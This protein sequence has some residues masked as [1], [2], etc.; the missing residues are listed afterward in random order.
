[1]SMLDAGDAPA[2]KETHSLEGVWVVELNPYLKS[3]VFK[4]TTVSIL[5]YL[6]QRGK[7]LEPGKSFGRKRCRGITENEL[8]L[9]PGVLGPKS[10]SD[11]D[12]QDIFDKSLPL[13]G[14]SSPFAELPGSTLPVW[15]VQ[16]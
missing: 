11:I 13:S 8:N 9:E 4:F 1:M 5:E 15:V 3:S 6:Y 12:L 16:L 14:L 7:S 2:L 10:V